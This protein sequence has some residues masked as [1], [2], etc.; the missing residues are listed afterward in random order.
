[1]GDRDAE[2]IEGQVVTD[3]KPAAS[4]DDRQEHPLG[5]AARS[6]SSRSVALA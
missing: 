3:Q 4:M 6:S 2:E 5:E 1:M